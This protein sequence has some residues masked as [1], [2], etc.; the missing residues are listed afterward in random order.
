[1]SLTE[2][3]GYLVPKAAQLV[4]IDYIFF[5]L[6]SSVAFY[7]S[8]RSS[9]YKCVSE[10]GGKSY[11]PLSLVSWDNQSIWSTSHLAYVPR[12][13]QLQVASSH[14]QMCMLR[15]TYRP[16]PCRQFAPNF[17]SGLALT[18]HGAT[19]TTGQDPH[20]GSK[21]AASKTD[22]KTTASKTDS[23][24]DSK[25]AACKRISLT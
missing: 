15:Q 21:T 11:A 24:T 8:S 9:A 18:N 25:T 6:E 4:L 5:G 17:C 13:L 12:Q 22:S 1:M 19:Q 16:H 20:N 10:D 14:Q 2:L 23:K 7:Q 3:C